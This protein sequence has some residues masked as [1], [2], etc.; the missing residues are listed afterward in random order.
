VSARVRL[1][2]KPYAMA[3]L[4]AAVRSAIDDTRGTS[5]GSMLA[6]TPR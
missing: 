1:L 5:S 3:A 2:H 4:A 6:A